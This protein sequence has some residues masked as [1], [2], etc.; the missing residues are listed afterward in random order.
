MHSWLL[1]LPACLRQIENFALKEPTKKPIWMTTT[2]RFEPSSNADI[3]DLGSRAAQELGWRILDRRSMT[4]AL[5]T[6]LTALG[7][8]PSKLGWSDN[9]QFQP[10]VYTEFNNALLAMLCYK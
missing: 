3:D 8:Q 10:Y 5:K 2:L 9:S 1:W 7:V 4:A 6:S